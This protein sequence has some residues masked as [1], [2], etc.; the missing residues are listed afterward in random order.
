MSRRLLS[1]ETGKS[2]IQGGGG[3]LCTFMLVCGR[4]GSIEAWLTSV[5]EMDS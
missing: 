5:I 1:Q 4:G 3:C 2:D